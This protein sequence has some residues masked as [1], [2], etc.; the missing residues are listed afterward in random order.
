MRRYNEDLY[1]G[2]EEVFEGGLAEKMGLKAGDIITAINGEEVEDTMAFRKKLYLMRE[3]DKLELTV[4][5]D[6]QTKTLSETIQPA[7]GNS[8]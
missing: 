2:E 5:Q 1:K 4:I 3:G 7:D 6:G 8:L